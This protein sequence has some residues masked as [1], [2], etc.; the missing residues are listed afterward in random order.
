MA[1][2]TDETQALEHHPVA[3]V[4]DFNLSM[5]VEDSGEGDLIEDAEIQAPKVGVWENGF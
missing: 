3:A 4:E 1:K 2:D 5:P